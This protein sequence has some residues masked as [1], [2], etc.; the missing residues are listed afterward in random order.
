MFQCRVCSRLWDDA[1]AEENAF[2]C[3]HRC[4]GRLEPVPPLVLPDRE[5]IDPDRLAYPVALTSRRLEEALRASTDVLKTLFLLKD[6]VEAAIKFLGSILLVEYLRSPACTPERNAGL[7]EKLIR[8][9]LGMW[10]NDVVRPL[11]LWLVG[12]DLEPGRQV[13]ALFAEPAIKKGGNAS[14]TGLFRRCSSFV[15]YR[16]DA[17][18]HGARRRDEQ[19]EADLRDWLPLVRQLQAGLAELAPWRLVLVADVDRAQVWMGPHPETATEPGVFARAQVG[20]FALRGL[21]GQVRDLFP[22]V[23]YLPVSNQ[24]HRL[25]FY[26][27]LHRYRATGKDIL[28]LEYDEGF[29]QPRPEPIA[30]L[31]A[32]FTAELLAEK[33]G[34][35]RGQMEVIEGRVASFGALID[36]HA[37]IVGRRF[38]ID[39]V[40]RFV[41]D[42]DRGLLVIEGEPGKGKTALLAHLVDEVYGH[43]S[44]QPIHFF[45]R[46]TA[47]IT[48]PDV[49][50]KSLYHALLETH[51]LTEA[52]ESQRQTD[53]ESMFLKLSNLLNDQVAQRLTPGRP[54]LI[55]IDA[56]DESEP[57]ASGRTAF[58][59]IPENLPA[60]VFVIA[61]SRPV[62]DRVT[63]ARRPFL[64]WFDLDGPDHLQDNLNDGLDYA[65]RELVHSPLSESAIAEVARVAAGNFLVLMLLCRQIRTDLAPGEVSAFLHRLATDGARDKLGFIYQEFWHRITARLPRADLLVLCDVAGVLV[66]AYG[67]LT[68]EIMGGVLDLRA[69]DW[70]F[71][72]RHLH[73]YLT[74]QRSEEGA[75]VET[76]YRIYH[77]SFADFLR[78]QTAV[79]RPRYR[80]RL[81]DYVLGWSRHEGYGRLYALRFGPRH[82]LEDERW[83]ELTTLWLDPD[84]GLFFHEA[85]AE[86]GMLID[87]VRDFGEAVRCVPA[88]HPSSRFLRLLEQALRYDVNFLARHPTTI[89]QCFW[90]RG[91]WYDCPEGALHYQPP[92]GVWPPDGPPWE[93]PEPKL[94]R[95]LERWRQA[96]E[97]RTPGFFWLRSMRPPQDPLGSALGAILRGHEGRVRSV[98]FAPQSRR[99]VS[100]SS[101][102]TVRVWDAETGDQVARLDGHER[103]VT[104]VAFAPDSGRIV[105]GS[106]DKTVRV[107]DAETGA[108]LARLDGH[109]D[110]VT[111]VA[112]SPDGRRIVSGSSDKT[113]RVWDAETG[114]QVAGVDGHGHVWS[115]AC[116]PDGR[117]I[118]SGSSDRTVRVWNA[119]TGAQIARLDGHEGEI[120][121]VAF[122]PDGRRIAS[123]SDDKTVRVWD[124]ESGAQL[125]RL[126]GHEH[127]VKSVAFAPDGRRI[128]SGSLD[129]TVRIWDAE[130]GAQL[131][132]FDGHENCVT[133]VTFA[134]DGRRIVSGSDDETVRVW[135]AE[136]GAHLAQ[137]DG[138]EAEILSVAFAPDGRRIASG[139]WDRTV[140]VW[141]AKTGAQL[142]RLVGDDGAIRSVAFAPDGRRIVS[143]SWERTVRV[144]DAETGAELARL[145]G[146]E[147]RVQSVAFSPDGRRIVSGSGDMTVRVWDAESGAQLAL[148]EGYSTVGRGV[149]FTRDGRRVVNWHSGDKV[150]VWDIDSGAYTDAIEGEGDIAGAAGGVETHSFRA[151]AWVGGVE[152]VIVR[153]ADG[154]EVAWFP[155]AL[156]SRST[157]PSTL[158]WAG[159]TSFEW[160]GIASNHFYL[161]RLEG[162]VS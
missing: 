16:N 124:A 138:H 79:D 58:Q 37:K 52:E 32:A 8:P 7:L 50:V 155:A 143:G 102:K 115:V 129:R 99:I 2:R 150:R 72:L 98:A 108:Q 151:F 51:N 36:E 84:R 65:R 13:G 134:L 119:E 85:K 145:D 27:C 90:N 59:R 118:V 53:P 126:D 144:W 82:L 107:W 116:A 93:G 62:A 87:L 109:E 120:F 160:G 106:D 135:D 103:G 96:K 28:A 139:S 10:V 140:R 63:L 15:S 91:W 104:S 92:D 66:A 123:G 35:H 71:A 61:T 48:D 54:Q 17:L 73:E 111:S 12:G 146:H 133:S 156:L 6:A 76:F 88:Q 141:D 117:R 142:S 29:K 86:A 158:I 154:V 125:T 14:E 25:H 43:V 11:S 26:D 136:T 38:V 137:L 94:C 112:F 95:L 57:T 56:L 31:E 70:D 30:G 159:C 105:S 147:A 97:R 121:S 45:Y 3:F 22:F 24:E 162:A 23:C 78:V 1:N 68:A 49:C 114:D 113:V 19:Y 47:G 131:A 46:R 89:F 122:A 74:V 21:A 9:A 20:H 41:R 4:G 77:E 42:H 55:F 149:A 152:T 148:L 132:R 34:R 64:H 100:G 33:F 40:A 80:Q 39:H 60:G 110:D 161:F 18:G 83:D 130:T 67:P 101:D 127:S 128:L 5:G 69:G 153:K 81:G 75:E 44:P 157:H